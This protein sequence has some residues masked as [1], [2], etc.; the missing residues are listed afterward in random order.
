[1]TYSIAKTEI[2]SNGVVTNMLITTTPFPQNSNCS[3]MLVQQGGGGFLLPTVYYLKLIN[4][5]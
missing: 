3:R 2:I 5:I 1:M 4:V